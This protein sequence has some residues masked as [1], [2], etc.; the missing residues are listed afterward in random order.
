MLEYACPPVSFRFSCSGLRRFHGGKVVAASP[1]V[2]V[3]L[4]PLA[5]EAGIE[6]SFFV[7]KLP[8][9]VMKALLKSGA[10]FGVG[11]PK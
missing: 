6:G 3:P 1:L 9:M 4:T 10:W 5:I 2:S 8:Q 11:G 7:M